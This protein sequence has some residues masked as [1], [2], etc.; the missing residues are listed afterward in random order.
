MSRLRR[1]FTRFG[2]SRETAP[3]GIARR[4]RKDALSRREAECGG[5][6]GLLTKDGA[7]II[8]VVFERLTVEARSGCNA[9]HAE[10]RAP[11]AM[12]TSSGHYLLGLIYKRGRARREGT[13]VVEA[14]HRGG[15]GLSRRATIKAY[16]YDPTER[17]GTRG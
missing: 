9:G 3:S 2:I 6:A 12:H 13:Q 8:R 1:T 14:V 15:K 16:F 11:G 5:S 4:V 10:G 17:E 7:A